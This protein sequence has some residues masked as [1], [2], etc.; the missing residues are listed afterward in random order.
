[1]I[2]ED[3]ASRALA[4]V[5]RMAERQFN[6]DPH[7]TH[8]IPRGEFDEARRI[9]EMMRY[10]EPDIFQAR[11]VVASVHIA[12]GYANRDRS[13]LD[14]GKLD[15]DMPMLIARAGIQRGRDLATRGSGKTPL[16]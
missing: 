4:L 8:F 7:H 11:D 6:A 2:D 1:M 5:E 3:V 13:D 14:S 12:R 10:V 16:G 9:I 15:N